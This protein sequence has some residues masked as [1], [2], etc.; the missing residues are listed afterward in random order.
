MTPMSVY[1]ALDALEEARL[2]SYIIKLC[3]FPQDSSGILSEPR[4]DLAVVS[5]PP[6]HA[7]NLRDNCTT[8]CHHTQQSCIM[9]HC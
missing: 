8:L 5:P 2:P 4:E 7:A 1:E 6:L 9:I 3:I